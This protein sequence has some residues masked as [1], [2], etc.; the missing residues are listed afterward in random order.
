MW[1]RMI[2]DSRANAIWWVNQEVEPQLMTMAAVVG[3]GGVPVWLPAGGASAAP[4][5]TLFGRPVI[6]VQYTAAL[7]TEGDIVFA[8][9]AQYLSINKGPVQAATSIHVQFITGEQAF[10]FTYRINGQPLWDQP[11]TP[12]NG[13]TTYS[14][15]VTLATR[16]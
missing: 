10:R 6:P 1:N 8:D 3:V 15:I 11:F 2:A 4:F 14:P 13:T 16:G 9:L 5:S 7:G 12:L